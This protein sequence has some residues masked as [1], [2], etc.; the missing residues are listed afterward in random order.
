M[1]ERN[2]KSKKREEYIKKIK[3]GMSNDDGI[4]EMNRKT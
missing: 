4:K 3:E 1:E 2:E